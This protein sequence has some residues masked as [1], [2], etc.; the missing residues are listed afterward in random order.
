MDTK[1]QTCPN[2]STENVIGQCGN[3]GRPFVLSEA[4]PQGRARKLG[5][6]PLAEVPG[7]LSSRPCSYCRLRQK[8]QMM[9]AMS[10]AR[11]QRTC[12]VC[13]TECLSG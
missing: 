7:G 13:H 1:R 6:G 4:F 11:R 8:G 10:A 2:C 12:P 3:C 5:D 9:E